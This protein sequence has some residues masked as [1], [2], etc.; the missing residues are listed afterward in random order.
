MTALCELRQS[1]LSLY[2]LW[3]FTNWES[4]LQLVTSASFHWIGTVIALKHAARKKVQ[5]LEDQTESTSRRSCLYRPFRLKEATG[6]LVYLLHGGNQSPRTVTTILFL[7]S[8][9][10]SVHRSS[11]PKQLRQKIKFWPTLSSCLNVLLDSYRLLTI[12]GTECLRKD[13][14]PREEPHCQVQAFRNC[15]NLFPTTKVDHYLYLSS[16]VLSFQ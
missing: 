12:P 13:E 4:F 6:V 14:K 1:C 9:V 10:C 11:C 3:I 15:S 5:R 8:C 2:H 7:F 16:V